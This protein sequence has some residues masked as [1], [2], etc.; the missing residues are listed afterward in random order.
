MPLDEELI[1]AIEEAVAEADQ[2]TSV[3]KRLI[4]WVEALSSTDISA[5][6]ESSFLENVRSE[7][8]ISQGDL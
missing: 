7:I 4:A 5:E 6:D 1:K 3:A 2:S 8:R